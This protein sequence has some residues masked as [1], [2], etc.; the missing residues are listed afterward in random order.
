M[1]KTGVKTQGC[2]VDFFRPIPTP[3]IEAKKINITTLRRKSK[4]KKTGFYKKAHLS[5]IKNSW[6]Y[7][8]DLIILNEKY[9]SRAIRQPGII[10]QS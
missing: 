2:N 9:A 1:G 5:G 8:K 7:E 4:I 10:S 3:R 6:K